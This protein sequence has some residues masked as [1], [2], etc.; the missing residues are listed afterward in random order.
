VPFLRAPETVAELA[1]VGP[2]RHQ[3]DRVKELLDDPE[4]TAVVLTCLPEELPVTET[5]EAT[6]SLRAAELPLGGVVVNQVTPDLLASRGSRLPS[7]ARDSAPLIDAAASSGARLDEESI[8]VLLAEA[9]DRQR[10]VAR[11]QRLLKELRS[12]LG[13]LP[14]VELPMLAGGVPGPEAVRALAAVLADPPDGE[15]GGKAQGPGGPGGEAQGGKAQGP[16]PS[17]R[18][19]GGKGSSKR[20]QPAGLEAGG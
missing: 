1:R 11:E 14:V 10:L 3:A 12:A 7:L 9:R 19:Q 5:I 16:G 13:E 2:I 8:G 20:S 4:M 17:G 18:A 6:G 15:A